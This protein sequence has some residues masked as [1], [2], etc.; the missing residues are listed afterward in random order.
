[1]T[2]GF[3]S[4]AD[5]HWVLVWPRGSN[6]KIHLCEGKPDPGNTGIAFYVKGA[7]NL[8]AKMKRAG[9]KFTREMKKASW[10]IH[11]MFADRDGNGYWLIEGTGP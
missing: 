5:S 2:L 9:V 8:A 3:R 10:G 11:G 4:S 1:K 6:V 7:E